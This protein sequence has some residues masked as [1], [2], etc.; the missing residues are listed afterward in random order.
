MSVGNNGKDIR[1]LSRFITTN[2]DSGEAVFSSQLTEDMPIQNVNGFGFSLAYTTNR[3]PATL[4]SATD[5]STYERYLAD[6]PGLVV[7]TGTVCRIVDLPPESE[8]PMHRTVSLDYGVVLEGE[9]ELVLDSG[10]KRLMQRGDVAIQRATSHAWK[11]VTPSAG[12]ARM[13]YV[14][15]PCERVGALGE[16]TDGIDVKKSD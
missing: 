15:T 1:P 4:E 10:E 6:P 5:I 11:N 13:L 16:K 14:L 2:T 12:W 7:S 9:V 8:S 3:F